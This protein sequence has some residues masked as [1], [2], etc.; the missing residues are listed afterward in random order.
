MPSLLSKQMCPRCRSSTASRR[1]RRLAVFFFDVLVSEA[2][3][4]KEQQL[5]RRYLRGN[6][7]CLE[8]K[9]QKQ[10]EELMFVRHFFSLIHAALLLASCLRRQIHCIYLMHQQQ[11]ESGLFCLVLYS[12][13]HA[14]TYRKLTPGCCRRRCRWTWRNDGD[15]RRALAPR[16]RALL[17]DAPQRLLVGRVL[18]P[19]ADGVP[20]VCAGGKHDLWLIHQF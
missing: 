17:Q 10:Q 13:S 18:G 20:G 9:Q 16:A 7:A 5:R 19:A 14:K 12:I 4:C 2:D 1:W 15:R 8:S 3:T 6:Q 11:M